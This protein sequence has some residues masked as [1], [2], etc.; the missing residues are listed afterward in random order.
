MSWKKYAYKLNNLLYAIGWIPLIIMSY[1]ATTTDEII[2]YTFVF[3]FFY[4]AS[5]P[6][7]ISLYYFYF[8]RDKFELLPILYSSILFLIIPLLL[9]IFGL[10]LVSTNRLKFNINNLNT[11]FVISGSVLSGFMW[12]VKD[13]LKSI[14]KNYK[15]TELQ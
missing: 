10:F 2:S 1:Q 13:K 14:Q 6:F 3:V 5:M 11:L 15:E 7:S 8:K 9:A 12:V 4:G